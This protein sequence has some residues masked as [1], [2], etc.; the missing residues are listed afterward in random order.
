MKQTSKFL[1]VFLV[2]ISSWNMVAQDKTI[3]GTV[4]SSLDGSTLPGVTVVL[5]ENKTKGVLTDFDGD[6]YIEAS[7]G[8]SLQFSFL[9]M[10]TVTILVG[11]SD[12][13]DVA[14]EEDANQL[15]EV[16]I[17]ALGITKESKTIGYAMS[18]LE[19]SELATTQTISPVDAL[20]GKVAGV[21][22]AS[23]DGG[24]F[25]NSRIQIRGVS[26]LNSGNNQPIFVIDGVI[27]ENST[28]N[29]SAD[30]SSSANDYGN[31]LK[32]LNADEYES[33]SVLKGAAATALYGSR[34]INGV[35]LIK[36]K[37]GS[38]TKG[39]GISIK[40]T[41][42]ID[43]VYKQ[44]ALQNIYGPGTLAAYVG[45]G[46]KNENDQY[47]R[48]DTEQFYYNDAGERTLINNAGAGLSYG[49]KF[50]GKP[51]IDYDGNEIPYS[52]N[53]NNMK[54]VYDDGF[55]SNTALA[56]S[57]GNEDGNFYLSDSYTAKT[58]IMP[59]DSFNRNALLFTGSYN[60]ASW[61]KATA[62]IS[63]T[64][65]TSKNPRNDISQSFFT[66][67]F[68]RIY[69]TKKY[70]KEQYW[71]APHG[72]VTNS[73][74]GDEF[75]NAPN[76][77]LWFAYENSNG[78]RD[79]Y[80]TRPVVRLE[81]TVTDWLTIIAEGNMNQYT[82][83][84][85]V[86][87][88]GSGFANDGGYYEL[89]HS[90]N[91]SRTGKLSFNV[92]KN[93]T[94]DITGQFIL[95]GEMWD[96]ENSYTRS[97]TDG[98][99]VV[100]GKYFLSNSKKTPRTSAG[101][102]GTKQINSV[103]F[104]ASFGYKNQ[105]FLDVTGRNDWSSALVYTNGTGNY[106]YFYPSVSSAW[107]FTETFNT[108]D[109]F[110]FGKLRASWAQV[111]SDTAAYSI[112]K[113]YGLST[114]ELDG[115]NFVYGNSVNGTTVDKGIMPE[116]KNSFEIGADLRF[117]SNR[118]GVDFSYYNETIGDQIGT[119][120]LPPVSGYSNLLTNIGTLSNY[121][122]ELTLTGTP[123]K[124]KDFE[125]R[126][127]FNYW[128]NTTEVKELH[129][130]YGEYKNL[131]GSIGYGNFRV[132]SVAFEGGDY[133]VLMSDS[134]IK[135]YQATNAAGEPI[136]DPRNGMKVMEWN[137]FGQGARYLRSG[138]VEEVGKIQPDFEGSFN[139]DFTYK[140]I[141]LSILLDA[142]YG[143][144]I[145]SYSSKYG[146]AYGYLERSL[147]GRDPE[148]GGVTWT[149]QY[150]DQKGEV[151]SDG[152]IPEGIF[153]DGQTVTAP[154]GST[155]D[156]GGMTYEEAYKEGFVEPS[157]A[158]YF[159]YF[160]NSWSRGVVNDDWFAEVKYI[161]IRN[162]SI[163]YNLPKTFNE[164]IG[165]NNLYIGLNGRN[166]GYLYNSLPNDINP[167]SFRGTTSNDSFRERGFTPYT[168]TYMMTVAIDF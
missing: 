84:F 1:F 73:A 46:N 97:W 38:G 19:G 22:V 57:G 167:E 41:S 55:T 53:K 7:V 157:H 47:Y 138:T 135:K 13:I 26:T 45:Y 133:G 68:E 49:P 150:E 154:D 158:S 153:Q 2:I 9:G 168:A 20:Q 100:P 128:N 121:G 146:T 70:S 33:V 77:G 119:V 105:L 139:N 11:S 69:D 62:S 142:R 166:L 122:I 110:T 136:D 89:K 28:S 56:L 66:G 147:A 92:K 12:V 80:V 59:N 117:F 130:D 162:V 10:K 125:W 99:L 156:V 114:W 61:L 148:H 16:V 151:F 85:E 18:E 8:Q 51:I 93:I 54:D 159:N 140:G 104:M 161:A 34:G 95:G 87:N 36:T 23:S 81:A 107:V 141:T 39:I 127:T 109:W 96:N 25:G 86:K 21:S 65:S 103:Y 108:P 74:Y 40:Q 101:V 160:K 131:G 124:T 4:T 155:V 71:L 30:W 90:N 75:A 116:R 35:I 32:N 82:T 152:I 60:L 5:L 37:D 132:G 48:F 144:H 31:I 115:G 64:H 17:T 113:G 43:H 98:G 52:A 165:V 111:G 94:E 120:P 106:S 50:D 58:G 143:G 149:S 163:G 78:T 83:K 102:S 118:F 3:T 72:G 79:E 67:T 112:N 29:N 15:D 126:T 24:L 129:E 88:L 145:A 14:L 42:G 91:V 27:L 76:R 137:N 44:P 134:A 63:Y 164:K 123:I 6:Y